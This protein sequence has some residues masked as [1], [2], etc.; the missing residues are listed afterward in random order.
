VNVRLSASLVLHDPVCPLFVQNAV[1]TLAASEGE[2]G[3]ERVLVNGAPSGRANHREQTDNNDAPN[4]IT[5]LNLCI[6]TTITAE[7]RH[8]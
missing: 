4:D 2:Q 8:L 6:C 7:I 5:L 1:S 3:S